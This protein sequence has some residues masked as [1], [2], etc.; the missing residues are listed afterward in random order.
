MEDDALGVGDG[1]ASTNADDVGLGAGG[2]SDAGAAD[3][4]GSCVGAAFATATSAVGA[5]GADGGGAG[6]HAS[7]I[8]IAAAA[9]RADQVRTP[10]V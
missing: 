6:W 3:T 10:R 7:G 9:R 8:V 1:A 2:S 4:G 5:I